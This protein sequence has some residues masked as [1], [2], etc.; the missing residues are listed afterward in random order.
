MD[1]S[2]NT[3]LTFLD[4][5]VNDKLTELNLKNSNNTLLTYFNVSGN[6]ELSCIEV[7]NAEWST[8]NWTNVDSWVTFSENCG[9]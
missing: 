7:D 4:I 1:L 2:Q 8:A 3:S 9:Y 5:E 6:E